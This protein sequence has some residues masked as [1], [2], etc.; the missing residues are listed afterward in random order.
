MVDYEYITDTEILLEKVG[1]LGIEEV[2]KYNECYLNSQPE[3][4]C[5]CF[6]E[7]R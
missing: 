5:L 2:G 6:L 3:C 1:C 4:G 7:L